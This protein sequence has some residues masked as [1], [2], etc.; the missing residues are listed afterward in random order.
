M[1]ARLIEH[2]WLGFKQGWREAVV[3]KQAMIA[4]FLVG[5]ASAAVVLMLLATQ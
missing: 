5:A 1:R 2:F 4:C 3:S